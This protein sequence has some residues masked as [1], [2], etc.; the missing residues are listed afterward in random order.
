MGKRYP[1]VS[2]SCRHHDDGWRLVDFLQSD[3]PTGSRATARARRRRIWT[4]VLD[5]HDFRSLFHATS[6]RLVQV[7]LVERLPDLVDRVY[8]LP[9][10]KVGCQNRHDL[11]FAGDVDH[12]L[13][14]GL[15]Q[16]RFHAT[17]S[18]DCG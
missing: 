11:V 4:I 12:R 1:P 14:R 6:F 3:L 13:L 8:G 17:S 15:L 5:P 16:F 10:D 2:L 18:G 9:E 7:S